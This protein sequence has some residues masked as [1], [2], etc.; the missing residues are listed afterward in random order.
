MLV[1]Y[2]ILVATTIADGEMTHDVG[3]EFSDELNTDVKLII[4]GFLKRLISCMINGW[5]IGTLEI[6]GEKPLTCLGHVDLLVINGVEEILSGV[7][8]R[9][10]RP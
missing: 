1:K 4:N 9:E 2:D 5:W 10:T 3:L 6:H 7:G 8:S